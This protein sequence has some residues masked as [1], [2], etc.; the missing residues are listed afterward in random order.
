MEEFNLDVD[1]E[2]DFKAFTE[3]VS[4]SSVADGTSLHNPDP[5]YRRS[6]KPNNAKAAKNRVL[7]SI[8]P[9]HKKLSLANSFETIPESSA[10]ELRASP[11]SGPSP[12]GIL[13]RLEARVVRAQDLSARG[14]AKGSARRARE[15][16]RLGES[17]GSN[18]SF[19][20]SL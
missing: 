10:L 17:S 4:G 13:K 1:G 9:A 20:E 2:M 7:R 18:G 11:S 14:S 6:N 3:L 5:R 15:A 12:Q 16:A 19:W 8:S